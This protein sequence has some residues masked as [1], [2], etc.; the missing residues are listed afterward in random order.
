MKKQEKSK[1]AVRI[2][3]I[4]LAALMVFSIAYIGIDAILQATSH[5][6]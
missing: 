2:L 3:C 6:H 1:L 4:V 5:V